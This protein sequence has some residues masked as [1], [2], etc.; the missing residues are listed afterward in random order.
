M[1]T[2]IIWINGSNGVSSAAAVIQRAE[3]SPNRHWDMISH[4][5][6]SSA[7]GQ[8]TKRLFDCC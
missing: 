2:K 7:I 1:Q 3:K 6:I 4:E 5:L 8:W